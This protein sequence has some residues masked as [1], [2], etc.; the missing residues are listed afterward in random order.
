MTSLE[1]PLPL[2]VVVAGLILVSCLGFAMGLT[3]ALKNGK[4]NTSVSTAPLAEISGVP[5]QDAA[6]APLYVPPPPEKP[7]VK[8]VEVKTTEVEAPAAVIEAP[9]AEP[10][11]VAEKKSEAAPTPPPTRI[12]D[13]Y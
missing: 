2:T 10:A 4:S 1:R 6:P 8:A 9:P 5:V 3:N 7:K 12:E 11:P 13:L